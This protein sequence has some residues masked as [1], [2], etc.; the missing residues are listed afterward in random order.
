MSDQLRIALGRATPDHI[1]LMR[2]VLKGSA[3]LADVQGDVI[4][5]VQGRVIADVYRALLAELDTPADGYSSKLV[6]AARTAREFVA[7]AV[8]ELLD[9]HAGAGGNPL[10]LAL[11]REL[12]AASALAEGV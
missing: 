5:D 11:A 12:G 6:E 10:P 2:R 3:D 8:C 4:G 1:A 7:E 9:I